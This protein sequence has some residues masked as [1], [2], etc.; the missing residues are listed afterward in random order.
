[1]AKKEGLILEEKQKVDTIR[2]VIRTLDTTI[3]EHEENMAMAQEEVI[4]FKR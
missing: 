1:M 4:E 2:K 3:L